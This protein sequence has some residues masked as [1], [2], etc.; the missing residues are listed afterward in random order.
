MAAVKE[1]S[2]DPALEE[3]DIRGDGKKKKFK[4]LSA[5]RKLFGKKRK[6]EESVVAVKAQSTT[7]L[8]SEY[9][10]EE[11]D[12]GGFKTHQKPLS[13]SGTRSISEDSVF[14]P[15]AREANISVFPKSAV[16]E[17]SLP[18]SAF[19]SELFSKLSKRRSQYSD[20]DHDDGLPRSPV[21]PVT[22]ADV[23][24]G[25]SLK[26][27]PSGKKSSNRD[28][29]QS[30]ISVDSSENEEEDL[31]TAKWKASVPSRKSNS[32][33]SLSQ[34]KMD[35]LDFTGIEKTEV[36]KSSALKDRMS[37]KPKGRKATRQSRK[38]KESASPLSL[39][40]L[41][42]E[43]PTRSRPEEIPSLKPSGSPVTKDAVKPT[44]LK[45]DDKSQ[46]SAFGQSPASSSGSTKAKVSSITVASSP[47]T[48][49][50]TAA[51]P[52]SGLSSSP[53]KGVTA[54]SSNSSTKL[55]GSQRF[56]GVYSPTSAGAS[57]PG[58]TPQASSQTT[59]NSSSS[60]SSSNNIPS[61]S[62]SEKKSDV[63]SA[64]DRGAEVTSGRPPVGTSGQK[65]QQQQDDAKCAVDIKARMSNFQA[66]GGSSKSS[67]SE[68]PSLKVSDTNSNVTLSPKED[69][70]LKRQNRSKTLPGTTED[71]QQASPRVQRA[72]SHR[73]QGSPA[74]IEI[75]QKEPVVTISE[76]STTSAASIVSTSTASATSGLKTSTSSS[77]RKLDSS[78]YSSVDSG[79]SASSEPSWISMVRKKKEESEAEVE[80]A[81]NKTVD[82]VKQDSAKAAASSAAKAGGNASTPKSVFSSSS[83]LEKKR[84]SVD[85]TSVKAKEA[86]EQSVKKTDNPSYDGSAKRP[87]VDAGSTKRPSIDIGSTRRESIEINISELS[88]VKALSSTFGSS[89]RGENTNRVGSQKD[90]TNTAGSTS[91]KAKMFSSSAGSISGNNWSSSVSEDNEKKASES[92]GVKPSGVGHFR[93]GSVK[94][95]PTKSIEGRSAFPNRGGSVKVSSTFSQLSEPPRTGGANT[96]ASST[97]KLEQKTD[98]SGTT[99]SSSSAS[100]SAPHSSQH[101]TQSNSSTSYH[102]QAVT[103][104]SSSSSSSATTPA[105]TSS[106]KSGLGT[107][108]GTK[109]QTNTASNSAKPPS[110]VQTSASSSSTS[111]NPPSSS[112]FGVKSSFASS[113]PSVKPVNFSGVKSLSSS[114]SPA[115]G[116]VPS[117]A[118]VSSSSNPVAAS[119]SSSVT[120]SKSSSSSS[121]S[122]S[123]T[124]SARAS[125]VRSHSSFV[126]S[127]ASRPQLST[128]SPSLSS[129]SSGI[130]KSP[131]MKAT[132]TGAPEKQEEK[133]TNTAKVPAWR[134]N[135]QKKNEMKIEI[136]ENS[137]SSSSSSSQSKSEN[138]KK[139]NDNS[140][141][142]ETAKKTDSPATGSALL[143]SDKASNRS[144]KVL[145][146][147]KNFQNLQVSS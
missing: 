144:S 3:E 89:S 111:A 78:R 32:E 127:P 119:V 80:D 128:T 22:T 53:P 93:G 19:Q 35:S 106:S 116:N 40:S 75:S 104:S 29:D 121:S 84:G 105:S 134:A 114:S 72:S 5:V 34:A 57:G 20:D 43:S 8:H 36:L 44:A 86:N 145:D 51:P 97:S 38:K 33:S 76:N 133:T 100:S 60:S 18:K 90:N 82:S 11:D 21:P 91:D 103:S 79:S 54:A 9:V 85:T 13:L 117:S 118:S 95:S 48:S 15:E 1:Y 46:V 77:V 138:L 115:S 28:S 113:S 30:L 47:A 70:K 31:F 99:S 27:T 107:S 67:A 62:L 4:P 83:Y 87:S 26:P 71:Q 2:G 49:P 55:S 135:L 12:D 25:G 10:E 6:K 45:S 24:M 147:V 96:S 7:A 123:T 59:A 39:P 125:S 130:T 37:I 102:A 42:E 101:A 17:E 68:S 110:G 142:A 124:P 63:S 74:K 23:I 132:S 92:S 73:V 94:T 120:P 69:Y 81:K 58:Q 131:S 14:S 88:S 122:S 66:F 64:S 112:Q 56:S 146:M 16:S 129:R 98:T 41:N 126:S 136:I 50:S 61:V 139:N 140:R 109:T 108:T 143:Q 141:V 65:Q 137:S 52:S